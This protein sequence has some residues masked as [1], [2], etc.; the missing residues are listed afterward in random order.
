VHEIDRD[1][2]NTVLHMNMTECSPICTAPYAF[3]YFTG[4]Y[5][6]LDNFGTT[7]TPFF[8]EGTGTD[9]FHPLSDAFYTTAGP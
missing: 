7:F 1:D 3:G 8:V 6:G 5:E 4:D 9:P 2:Y